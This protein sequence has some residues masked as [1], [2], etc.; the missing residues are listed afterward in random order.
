MIKEGEKRE[1][2]KILAGKLKER[3]QVGKPVHKWNDNTKG[4]LKKW[5][6][7]LW[8]GFIC[9]RIETSIIPLN[10]L[11]N[12]HLQYVGNFLTQT[13]PLGFSTRQQLVR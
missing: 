13:V 6:C 8:P 11:M 4:N 1:A 2:Y 12:L 7:R 3:R 9:L 5:V 10:F